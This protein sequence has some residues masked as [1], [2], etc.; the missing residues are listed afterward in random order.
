MNKHRRY[1]DILNI[2]HKS[3]FICM[4][5]LNAFFTL[6][7]FFCKQP[8]KDKLLVLWEI[9]KQTKLH[10]QWITKHWMILEWKLDIDAI[11]NHL[12]P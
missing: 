2:L 4:Y 7:P 12:Y 5:R 10:D 6:I 11:F 8:S 1:V 9:Y 3:H